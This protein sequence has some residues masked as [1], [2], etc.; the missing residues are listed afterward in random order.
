LGT[1]QCSIIIRHFFEYVCPDTDGQKEGTQI[2]GKA[3]HHHLQRHFCSS[4]SLASKGK[5]ERERE[6]GKI[7]NVVGV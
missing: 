5:G 7:R 6:M 2:A 3:D 4:G 1:P